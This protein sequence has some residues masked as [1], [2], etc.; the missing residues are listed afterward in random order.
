MEEEVVKKIEFDGE[1]YLSLDG[2]Q[3]MLL[4]PNNLDYIYNDAEAKPLLFIDGALDLRLYEKKLKPYANQ[5]GFPENPIWRAIEKL[6]R[7]KNYLSWANN[8]FHSRRVIK[9]IC[10]FGF[11]EIKMRLLLYNEHERKYAYRLIANGT[12]YIIKENSHE[13]LQLKS[14][15]Y[16]DVYEKNLVSH[17]GINISTFPICAYKIQT[18]GGK[19]RPLIFY[20]E[21]EI[22]SILDEKQLG[23]EEISATHIFRKCKFI[24]I[25]DKNT[26]ETKAEIKQINPKTEK[27]LLNTIGA[28]TAVIR[29]GKRQQYMS[30]T[31]L[32]E[33]LCSE[34]SGA[35]GLNNSNSTSRKISAGLRSLIET[36]EEK[37]LGTEEQ[38][39]ELRSLIHGPKDKK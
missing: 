9:T 30:N 16:C 10:L 20:S 38:I 13:K 1:S 22:T 35:L 32:S 6:T 21:K 23:Y 7:S 29:L 37:N 39:E 12:P 33:H 2:I 28:L 15:F 19:L 27:T 26:N 34:Y 25:S 8:F 3:A 24:E 31:Q 17:E 36:M 14:D 4:N 18:E 11:F 5:I